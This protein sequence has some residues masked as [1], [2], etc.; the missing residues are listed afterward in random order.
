MRDL[1]SRTISL[2]LPH[3]HD[4]FY[5]HETSIRSSLSIVCLCFTAQQ[6][7][8]PVPVGMRSLHVESRIRRGPL[9]DL[10]NTAIED[11]TVADRMIPS[12]QQQRATLADSELDAVGQRRAVLLTC[13]MTGAQDGRNMGIAGYSYDIV[14]KLYMPLLEQWGEVIPVSNPRQWLNLAV[15][16]ARKRGLDP[17]HVSFLPFQDVCLTPHA[18]NIVVPAWEFPDVPDDAF[19]G[20]PRNDWRATA[21]RCAVVAVGG[22]FTVR[23]L[24]KADTTTPIHVVPVPTP[25]EYFGL[26][27]WDI[28]ARSTVE[29]SPLVFE[30]NPARRV[31]SFPPRPA[32]QYETPRPSRNRD[33]LRTVSVRA[34]KR[35]VRP[36]LSERVGYTIG[37]CWETAKKAWRQQPISPNFLKFRKPELDLSGV[38]YTSILNP[39]DGRKNWPDLLTAF[40][41]ALGDRE[42]ATL[43][44]KLIKSDRDAVA[45]VVTYYR[46]RD[47]P[48]RC[49][50]VFVTGYLTDEQMLQLAQGSTYYIQAT[51]AEGNCLPLMNY[52]AAGRPGIS[53]DHSAIGDYFSDDVGFV[54]DSHPEPAAWPHDPRLRIR[55][56]WAR[57]VWPSLVAQIRESY[58]IAKND[59]AMYNAMGKRARQ[60]MLGWASAEAIW[61]RL[62][63]ALD[64]ALAT[65]SDQ[66]TTGQRPRVAA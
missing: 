36:L 15:Q 27:P 47:I 29:C 54:V 26:P 42:D 43:V 23:A 17:V 39:I 10:G 32:G 9:D 65:T 25:K 13:Y 28:G 38:V 53:P 30:N 48:H 24:C 51:R 45:R 63:G 40:L 55:T 44:V 6:T 46:M 56:T 19:D 8:A 33:L 14:A 20:N 3:P 41:T 35:L 18:P 2:N 12:P 61:P 22:P 4:R 11:V 52:L 7:P 62:K 34:Y 57:I 21:N 58:R 64:A 60:K 66:N 37:S 16:A 5:W 1:S 50:L 59:P 31:L 49:K